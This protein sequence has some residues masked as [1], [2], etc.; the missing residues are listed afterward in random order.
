MSKA[1]YDFGGGHYHVKVSTRE[2]AEDVIEFLHTQGGVFSE[3]YSLQ[4]LARDCAANYPFI[5]IDDRNRLT[6][7][8][9]APRS[10]Y[11]TYAEFCEH[12][13]Q[14]LSIETIDDLL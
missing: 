4:V 7:W 6:G 13:R 14:A 2:E 12:C 3:R 5:G 11:L 8:M 1:I 9:D 10:P